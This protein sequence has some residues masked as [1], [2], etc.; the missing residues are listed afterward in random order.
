M[1]N[2]NIKA[3]VS[4]LRED[5]GTSWAV[6]WDTN[7]FKVLIST[8]LSQRTKDAN[9]EK[10]SNRLFRRFKTPKQLANANIRTIETLIKPS[11]FYKVKA[12]RIREI[13]RQL[14]EKFGGT[15]PEDMDTL[16][17]L[18]GVGRKT[19][20]CVLVY[21]YNKPA[22]PVDTHV[23]RISNRIGWVRTRT[24]EQTEQ[25]LS[26][27]LPREYWIEINEL[28]VKYG[29]RVCHPINPKCSTCRIRKYCTYG[30]KQ[31]I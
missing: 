28:L 24:P 1:G 16:L 22:I 12:E 11:G 23:H 9:T 5:V 3:I 8:V 17:S 7:P 25:Q 6:V 29:Q 15:V 4:I 14:V 27:V 2:R 19:A 31:R 10:A 30:R 21:A 20:N 26:N 13:S 18:P